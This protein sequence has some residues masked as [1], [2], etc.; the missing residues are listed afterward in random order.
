MELESVLSRAPAVEEAPSWPRVP[1]LV[2]EAVAA[3]A[4]P[5]QETA[6]GAPAPPQA[7]GRV[8]APSPTPFLVQGGGLRVTNLQKTLPAN[9]AIVREAFG[10]LA[11]TLALVGAVAAVRSPA[12][13]LLVVPYSLVAFLFFS[14]WTLP[15]P[16]YLTGVLLLL[17]LLVLEGVRALAA[18]PALV[19]QR[20]GRVAGGVLAALI[21]AGLAVLLAR[22]SWARTSALPWVNVVL[23]ASTVLGVGVGSFV[24]RRQRDVAVALAI[25]LGLGAT[26]LW[27]STSTLGTRASFQEPQVERARATIAGSIDMPAVVLTTTAIGRPA[28]NLNYYTAAQAIYL[29]EMV[30]WQVQPRFAVGRLLRTGYAVYLLTTPE[31]AKQWLANENIATWYTGE[32]VR[33][34]PAAEASDYF[35]ASPFHRGIPLVLVRLELKPGV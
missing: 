5:A 4:A 13:F 18:S 21:V 10:D 28:E 15:G 19:A 2:R 24:A 29:E 31:A 14:M 25:G 17:P 30:R 8:P 33:S 6:A 3:D 20:F 1:S 12:L 32:I 35:V 26:L 11:L 7:G 34:I 9:V 27:R 23:V 16:R 22:S